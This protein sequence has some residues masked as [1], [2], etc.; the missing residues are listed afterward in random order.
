MKL[1][2]LILIFIFLYN[3]SGFSPLYQS[4][5]LFSDSFKAMAVTTDS[6][7]MSLSIKKDLLRKLPPTKENTQYIVKI[8]TKTE[9]SSTVTDTDR[10]TSGYE[11]ITIAKVAIYKR[12]KKYDKIIFSFEERTTGIFDFT[13]NQVL[14]TLA[15]RKKVLRISSENLSKNIL[16]RLILYF[17]ESEI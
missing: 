15:S 9:N 12:K 14:S 4:Q 16:D 1:F 11:I 2:S 8:E 6:K 10:K 7:E 17:S 5:S 13:P 3:C